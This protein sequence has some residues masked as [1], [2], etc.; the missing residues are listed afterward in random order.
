MAVG[1][2]AAAALATPALFEA[3]SAVFIDD[4]SASASFTTAPDFSRPRATPAD[5]EPDASSPDDDAAPAPTPSAGAATG[6]APGTQPGA[7]PT[8]HPTEGSRPR[9]EDRPAPF[10]QS[11][12]DQHGSSRSRAL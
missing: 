12:A 2:L 8:P 5:V 7:G 4:E 9:R 1:L 11:A 10:A 3:T 6:T